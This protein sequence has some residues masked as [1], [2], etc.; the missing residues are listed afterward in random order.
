[1]PKLLRPVQANAVDGKIRVELADESGAKFHIDLAPMD[2]QNLVGVLMEAFSQAAGHPMAESRSAAT[3]D[4]LQLEETP[5]KV[6]LRVFVAPSVF[7]EYVMDRDTTIA[8][9]IVDVLDKQAARK[10]AQATRPPSDSMN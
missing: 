6:Y 5:E 2:C 9:D 4:H 8:Q 7:H 3:V 10:V 1:M